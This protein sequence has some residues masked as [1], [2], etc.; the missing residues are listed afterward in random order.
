MD[1][2]FSKVPRIGRDLE[3]GQVC[4]IPAIAWKSIQNNKVIASEGFSPHSL[5]LRSL[6]RATVPA[7]S[8][9]RNAT[10]Y[11]ANRLLKFVSYERIYRKTT[12]IFRDYG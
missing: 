10:G 12:R 1:I 6:L 7:D 9:E 4:Q 2:A 5:G 11:S 3:F 8:L